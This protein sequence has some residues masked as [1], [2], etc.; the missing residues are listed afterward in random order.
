MGI[1][2]MP[3]AEHFFK[4]NAWDLFGEKDSLT[5]PVNFHKLAESASPR[6]VPDG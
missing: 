4:A 6:T 5:P 1:P 2:F 3:Q